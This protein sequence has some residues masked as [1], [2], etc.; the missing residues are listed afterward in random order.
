MLQKTHQSAK[1]LLTILNDILDFSKIE[2][3]KLSLE[4]HWFRGRDLV[5]PLADLFAPLAQKKGL[6]LKLAIHLDSQ[7]EFYADAGRV[8]QVLM[9][10]LSNAIKFTSTGEVVLTIEQQASSTDQTRLYFSIADTGMGLT[11]EQQSRLF[12]PFS[13][14]DSSITRKHGGT[15][16][17]LVIS[18][19]LVKVL[20][21]EG[22]HL[23]S[24][25]D[26]G[27]VFSFSLP[28]RVRKATAEETPL[29]PALSSSLVEKPRFTGKILLV[30]D[31]EINQLVAQTQLE[32]LG[33]VVVLASDGQQALTEFKQQPFDLVLMDIQMPVMDGYQATQA[34]RQ[35]N[36][37]I[38]IVAL[39]AAAM[40]ED[41]NKALA[42]GMND[43][44][45]KP[46]DASALISCLAQYLQ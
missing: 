35:I 14:A 32:K 17:G 28:C 9:N 8:R 4:P 33:L 6:R 7:R 36:P 5:R 38:P 20:G 31:N 23:E 2:A 41:K 12:Q 37:D 21:G 34:I 22:I 25:L 27:A 40:V 16:L 46:L 13:Q 39:T 1:I 24:A 44:L 29:S 26:Q 11:A 42:V 18:Q 10:L 43:H 45:A 30:E 3:G 15:G 19:R